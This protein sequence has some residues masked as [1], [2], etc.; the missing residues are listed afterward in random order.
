MTEEDLL[1]SPCYILHSIRY[2]FLRL[3]WLLLL[4][5]PQLSVRPP[6]PALA[7]LNFFF[8]G[9]VL[10]IASCSMLQTFVHSSS[11]TLPTRS[12]PLNLFIIST[13]WLQGIWYLNGLVVFPI[14]FN[15]SL[16]LAVS[17]SWSEP[18]S[19]LDLVSADYIELLHLWLQRI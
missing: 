7:F 2:I 5:F 4:F 13:V 8:F 17:S 18:K 19:L 10:V 6:Q 15:L 14:F 9:M 16:N 12:N 11:S 3:P 1:I